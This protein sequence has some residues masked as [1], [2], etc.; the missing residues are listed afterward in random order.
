MY[1]SNFYRYICIYVSYSWPNG[2]IELAEIYLGNPW[3]IPGG[4]IGKTKV[5][6]FVFFN[7]HFI[8]TDFFHEQRSSLQSSSRVCV[9]F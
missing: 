4:N 3:G 5:E 9:K 2:G 6:I 1:I 7:N 8:K